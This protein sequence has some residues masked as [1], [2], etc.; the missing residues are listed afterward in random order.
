M[1]PRVLSLLLLSATLAL[2]TGTVRAQTGGT[3]ISYYALSLFPVDVPN[4]DPMNDR[5]MK[6]NIYPDITPRSHVEV[7]GYTDVLGLEDR[8]QRLSEQRA[9]YVVRKIK[10]A[11]GP[12]G[13]AS[14]TGR[15][16]GE[17]APLYT[18]MLPEGRFYN[19]T[20]RVKIVT[21]PAPRD[22]GSK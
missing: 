10:A 22:E 21:P 9:D 17:T 19:R 4:L 20:V 16:V 5:I 14:L 11:K 6:E 2:A 1:K 8:N 13:Y 3:E 7:T 18:N 12:K 15:G